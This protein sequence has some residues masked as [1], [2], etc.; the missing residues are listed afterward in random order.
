[1]KQRRCSVTSWHISLEYY[2]CVA[3]AGTVTIIRWASFPFHT[4]CPSLTP[5]ALF[6]PQVLDGL[7]HLTLLSGKREPAYP[8]QLGPRSAGWRAGGQS[9]PGAAAAAA[10]APDPAL[11]SCPGSAPGTERANERCSFG[12]RAAL[13][14]AHLKRQAGPLYPLDPPDSPAPLASLQTRAGARLVVP[15]PPLL[16]APA[17]PCVSAQPG[18]NAQARDEEGA[19]KTAGRGGLAGRM[20]NTTVPGLKRR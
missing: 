19:P 7:P 17:P 9:P 13:R 20:R 14:T 10:A 3:V 12:P 15:A 18:G 1:M 5:P 6:L 2:H 8:E 11:S 4:P 16:R